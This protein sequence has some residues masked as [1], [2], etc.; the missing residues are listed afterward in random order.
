MSEPIEIV[1]HCTKELLPWM[2]IE[3]VA[4]TLLIPGF[5]KQ[6]ELLEHTLPEEIRLQ[7]LTDKPLSHVYVTA[8]SIGLPPLAHRE[9]EMLIK[10]GYPVS[11]ESKK[12]SFYG[13]N[14][15]LLLGDGTYYMYKLL[16]QI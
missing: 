11:K 15:M 14:F 16:L 4:W 9:I 5:S 10:E 8:I 1:V 7:C 12:F 13:G 2:P 6:I 3:E